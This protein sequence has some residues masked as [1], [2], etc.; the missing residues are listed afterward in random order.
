MSTVVD[1]SVVLAWCFEDEDSA[2]PE[3]VLAD[4]RVD[5]ATVPAIWPLEIANALRVAER[6]GRI[7]EGRLPG[8][9]EVISALPVTVEPT[10]TSLALGPILRL[11]RS[12][13]LSPYDASYLELAM[14]SGGT[15]AT[16]DRQ[17]KEAAV[18]LGVPVVN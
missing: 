1:A 6:R 15:L 3:R 9:L 11:A 18:R 14:R 7:L 17:L 4:V 13:K 5:G 12:Q 8:M 16:L 10:P 2:Y